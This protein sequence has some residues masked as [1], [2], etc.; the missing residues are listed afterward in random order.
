VQN[1]NEFFLPFLT[2]ST[3][4]PRIKRM[5]NDD[6]KPWP[7]PNNRCPSSQPKHATISGGARDLLGQ[8]PVTGSE[9]PCRTDRYHYAFSSRSKN[10]R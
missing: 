6:L 3:T 5:E 7:E 4:K 2:Y 1:V 8:L 9:E 10:E